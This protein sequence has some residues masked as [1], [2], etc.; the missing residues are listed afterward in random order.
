[1]YTLREEHTVLQPWARKIVTTTGRGRNLASLNSFITQTPPY[2]LNLRA[3]KCQEQ[4]VRRSGSR[5]R[6]GFERTEYLVAVCQKDYGC[7]V[8]FYPRD[9]V[10]QI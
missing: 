2:V 3:L 5:R 8:T 10:E 6:L 7:L 1:M 4:R 9:G